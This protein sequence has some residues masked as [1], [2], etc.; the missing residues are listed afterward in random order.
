MLGVL[1]LGI[2]LGM[3]FLVMRG[4]DPF[5]GLPTTPPTMPDRRL[6]P[7]VDHLFRMESNCWQANHW[8]RVTMPRLL[9]ETTAAARSDNDPEFKKRVQDSYWELRACGEGGWVALPGG[10]RMSLA[11]AMQQPV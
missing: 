9:H 8:L 6:Q 10:Q 2:A 4:G 1:G 3:F 7:V 5:E 11:Q